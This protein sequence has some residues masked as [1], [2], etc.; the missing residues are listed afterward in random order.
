VADI[1]T[2]PQLD[3]FIGANEVPLSRGG[4]WGQ[5]DA[6]VEP[7]QLEL[8]NNAARGEAHFPDANWKSY[9]TPSLFSG[10]MQLWGQLKDLLSGSDQVSQELLTNLGGSGNVLKGYGGLTRDFGGDNKIAIVRYDSYPSGAILAAQQIPKFII[11]GTL[12]CFQTNGTSLEY[13][14]SND[15]GANWTTLL[16][17]VDNTYRTS[18]SMVLGFTGM[19]GNVIGWSQFGGGVPGS[20]AASARLPYLGV[21]P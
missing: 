19:F 17:A 16:T 11:D 13:F 18:L 4:H 5:L 12:L 20:L 15:G 3:N 8:Q 2:T 9:W 7:R 21:G 6:V 1:R 14:Y 10:D